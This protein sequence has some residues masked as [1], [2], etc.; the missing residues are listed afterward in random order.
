LTAIAKEELEH[1]EQVNQ[2]LERRQIPLAPLNAPPYGKQFKSF[3]TS[4]R[5]RAGFRFIVGFKFN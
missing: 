4:P 1:F 2:W 5:T 3:G